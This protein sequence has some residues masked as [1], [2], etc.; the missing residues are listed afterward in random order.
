MSNQVKKVKTEVVKPINL[1]ESFDIVFDKLEKLE[2]DMVDSDRSVYRSVGEFVDS[3][4]TVTQNIVDIALS[5]EQLNA[6][7][8]SED[9]FCQQ[10]NKRFDSLRL[11]ADKLLLQAYSDEE[12][13]RV[14]R[15]EKLLERIVNRI[16]SLSVN[17][18]KP[19]NNKE[20]KLKT[21]KLKTELENLS[22][23][24]LKAIAKERKLKGY[25]R[26]NKSEL[27]KLLSE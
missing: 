24:Q 26:L 27:I 3:T 6:D 2:K 5:G 10:L 15:L 1:E 17:A 18:T 11:E 21:E 7:S 19:S 25:S 9:D 20:E 12:I 13:E 4:A 8:I 14:L 16:N 23:S 22:T